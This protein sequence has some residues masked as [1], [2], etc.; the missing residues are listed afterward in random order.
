MITK[1]RSSASSKVK[2]IM[3]LPILLTM[4][5][6]FSAGTGNLLKAQEKKKDQAKPPAVTNDI[7][8]QT[9]G[10]VDDSLISERDQYEELSSYPEYT[11]GQER[12]M[13]FINQNLKYPDEAK[14]GKIEGK[15]FVQFIVEKDG[16]LSNV[17][18]LRGIGAGCD[19]EVIRVVK[20]MPPWKPGIAHGKPTR[21]MF[22]LPVKFTLGNTDT[23]KK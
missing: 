10:S 7:Q 4:I 13:E 23:K 12:M 5:F 6:I 21:V 19:E 8:N 9:N 15:V 1:Q 20:M 2:V 22:A 14:K 3:A 18:V 11:G 17:K 16:R